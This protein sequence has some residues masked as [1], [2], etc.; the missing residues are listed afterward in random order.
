MAR[1]RKSASRGKEIGAV[2][3][4]LGG[5]AFWDGRVFLAESQ[6]EHRTAKMDELSVAH[7]SDATMVRGN[8][9][10][11]APFCVQQ[12]MRCSDSWS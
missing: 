8:F 1:I 5:S 12:Q 3:L 2:S 9:H 10:Q 7:R 6:G 4:L 11:W